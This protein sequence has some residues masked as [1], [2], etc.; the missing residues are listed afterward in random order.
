MLWMKLPFVDR[1]HP[2]SNRFATGDSRFNDSRGLVSWLLWVSS[3][4]TYYQE[5]KI[6]EDGQEKVIYQI[7]FKP[8]I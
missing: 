3:G 4:V 2:Q 1:I 5:V 7:N 6:L 8:H